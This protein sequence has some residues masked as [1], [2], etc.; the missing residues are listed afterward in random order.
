MLASRK[1][2]LARIEELKNAKQMS[3]DEI[4]FVRSQ[5]SEIEK[6]S[7]TEDYIVQLESSYKMVENAFDIVEKSNFAEE[8]I[9]GEDSAM[10]K[11]GTA[12]RMLDE[13]VEASAEAKSLSDRMNAIMIE[14][15]DISSDISNLSRDCSFSEEEAQQIRQDMDSWLSIRRKFG[16]SVEEVLLAKEKMQDRFS[17]QGDVKNNI[18]FET[19]KVKKL[20]EQMLPLAKEIFDARVNS[21]EKLSKKTESLLKKLGFKKPEFKIAINQINEFSNSCGS[22]CEFEFS[23]N[24]GQEVLPLAKI[25]SSGELARVMLAI[26]TTMANADKTPLLVFDEVDANVGGEIGA[27]V[28]SELSNLSKEHQVFCVTHLPQVAAFATTHLLVQKTQSTT[29]T[30]VEISELKNDERIL[31]LAR[32]LGDRN[33]KSAITH[34]KELLSKIN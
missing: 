8:L 31:E 12:K 10:D 6:L 9:S 34:A 21:A 20:E 15:N 11:L 29:E 3:A 22:M 17:T 27:A 32:M 7:L 16:N 18:V 13:I 5:I 2:S 19:E 28:A 30:N 24:P 4:E 23:A 25:A 33:S 1:E 26:K 14:L